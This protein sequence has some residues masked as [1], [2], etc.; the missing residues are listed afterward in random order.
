MSIDFGGHRVADEARATGDGVL[1]SSEAG[2]EARDDEAEAVKW[3][4]G[5]W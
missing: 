5:E 1:Q 2:D 4:A 3:G